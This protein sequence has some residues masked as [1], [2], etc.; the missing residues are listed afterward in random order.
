[1]LP[2]LLDMIEKGTTGT[3]NLVNP[4]IM[5]HNE[6]LSLYRDIVDPSKTWKNFTLDEQDAILKSKRSNNQL[7]TSLLQSMYPNVPCLYDDVKACIE[8]M[9]TLK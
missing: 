5:E 4:G 1:M 8:K 9:T 6:I 3:I 7:D 2:I